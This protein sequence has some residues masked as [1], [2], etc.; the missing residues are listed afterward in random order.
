MDISE[1]VRGRTAIKIILNSS[2]TLPT[3]TFVTFGKYFGLPRLLT[4]VDCRDSRPTFSRKP[5]VRRCNVFAERIFLFFQKGHDIYYFFS[6]IFSGDARM[7]I[8]LF[9]RFLTLLA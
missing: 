6:R 9:R 3:P 4:L 8:C 1:R 7:E 2:T 5:L